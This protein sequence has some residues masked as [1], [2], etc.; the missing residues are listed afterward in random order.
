MATENINR[1]SKERKKRLFIGF[2]LSSEWRKSLKDFGDAQQMA[3]ARW[4]PEENLHLTLFFIGLLSHAGLESLKQDLHQASKRLHTCRLEFQAITYA[5]QDG[6]PKMVW[7]QF[8]Q[9]DGF[10]A[11][12]KAL[13]QLVAEKAPQYKLDLSRL[14]LRD[15]IIP[16]IT[17]ARL[18]DVKRKDLIPPH[19]PSGVFIPQMLEVNG[20]ALYESVLNPKGARYHILEEFRF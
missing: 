10:T 8:Q 4:M 18:K 20:M 14:A 5:P 9:N 15:E 6:R 17:M 19:R 2:P 12:S 3:Y 1:G 11:L 16:H 13:Y 7:A